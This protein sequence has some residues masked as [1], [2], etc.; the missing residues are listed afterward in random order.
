[1]FVFLYIYTYKSVESAKILAAD[2]N[3]RAG[4]DLRRAE[5]VAVAETPSINVYSEISGG[6]EGIDHISDHTAQH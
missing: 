3:P 4:D 5:A 1:M 2:L 6:S